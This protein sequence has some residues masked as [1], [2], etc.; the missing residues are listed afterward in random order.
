MLASRQ[1]LIN[2]QQRIPGTRPKLFGPINIKNIPRNISM[3]SRTHGTIIGHIVF[4]ENP[5]WK[6]FILGINFRYY[7]DNII[8]TNIDVKI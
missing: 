1:R 4:H 3:K 7:K 2:Y 6:T 5:L 8:E